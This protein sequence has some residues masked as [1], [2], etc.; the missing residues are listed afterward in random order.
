MGASAPI[1]NRIAK[2]MAKM[3]GQGSGELASTAF[4]AALRAI[5]SYKHETSKE[6]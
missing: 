1:E 6:V 4:H 2:N 5:E 3:Y